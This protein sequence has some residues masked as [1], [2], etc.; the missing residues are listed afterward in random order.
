M[1]PLLRNPLIDS[2]A[3]KSTIHNNLATDTVLFN[4]GTQRSDSH[5]EGKKLM[6]ERTN[7]TAVSQLLL[8]ISLNILLELTG[9]RMVPGSTR[10]SGRADNAD[11]PPLN[12][13][14]DDRK[15]VPI[16]SKVCCPSHRM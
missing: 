3:G 14:I 2:A 8:D 6:L 16:I 13:A 1:I 10:R 15:K 5:F 9:R 4:Y 12:N 11:V 7:K